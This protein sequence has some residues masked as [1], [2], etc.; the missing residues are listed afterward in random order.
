MLNKRT[1]NGAMPEA[2]T[3]GVKDLPHEFEFSRYGIL[4]FGL[5]HHPVH[6]FQKVRN[7]YT[8]YQNLVR[9]LG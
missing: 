4:Y 6:P 3:D 2:I 8:A 5:L 9:A 7:P 1:M